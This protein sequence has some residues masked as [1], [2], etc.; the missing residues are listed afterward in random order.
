MNQLLLRV[1]DSCNDIQA[2]ESK[3]YMQVSAE[4]QAQLNDAERRAAQAKEDAASQK[5]RLVENEEAM[6]EK[7][8]EL[9]QG[10][11]GQ[12]NRLKFEVENKDAQIEKLEDLLSSEKENRSA[13][14]V[15]EEGLGQMKA[16]FEMTLR[17]MR[18]KEIENVKLKL[19]Q[20][21]EEKLSSIKT[22]YKEK[23]LKNKRDTR[24]VL[25]ETVK[26]ISTSYDDE[27]KILKKKNKDNSTLMA[28][29]KRT[30]IQKDGDIKVLQERV[31]SQEI[32]KQIKLQHADL[33]CKITSQLTSGEPDEHTKNELN[34]LTESMQFSESENRKKNLAK[35]HWDSNKY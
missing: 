1:F 13:G 26:T 5:E 19:K 24:K 16:H 17:E 31:K 12:V 34:R 33:L 29:L 18:G 25:D 27:I 15:S 3:K 8:N 2:A 11:E 14:G 23:V 6:R 22:E 35:Q 28:E 4:M 10:L 32:E 20:E 9:R 7:S 30:L 21:Y